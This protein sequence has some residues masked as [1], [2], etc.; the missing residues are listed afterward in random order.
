MVVPQNGWFIMENPTVLKWMIWGYHHLRKH[1]NIHIFN[2]KYIFNPSIFQPDMLVYQSV[3]AQT[4]GKNDGLEL[5]VCDMLQFHPFAICLN[6][7]SRSQNP[8]ETKTAFKHQ[9]KP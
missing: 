6:I 7:I 4:T 8:C 5:E 1:P 9:Q 2:R 3:T